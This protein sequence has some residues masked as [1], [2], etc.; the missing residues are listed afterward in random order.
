MHLHPQMRHVLTPSNET[1]PIYLGA[2]FYFV[3][4]FLEI[5]A[6]T[7]ILHIQ[8]ISLLFFFMHKVF[9]EQTYFCI[10]A[11]PDWGYFFRRA[12]YHGF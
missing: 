3:R 11:C 6:Q 8:A 2:V 10:S 12:A 1:A 9:L 4:L 7:G 5:L